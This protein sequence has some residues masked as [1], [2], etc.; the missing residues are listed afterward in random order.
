MDQTSRSRRPALAGA[1]LLGAALLAGPRLAHAAAPADAGAF[2]AYLTGRFAAE[3]GDFALALRDFEKVAPD[4]ADRRDHPAAGAAGRRDGDSPQAID[5]ARKLPDNPSPQLVLA[6]VDAKTATGTAPSAASCTAA[7]GADAGAAAAAGRL[8]AAGRRPHRRGAG[9]ARRG[10]APARARSV[11][12]LHAAMI[13]DL[14]GRRPRRTASTRSP[15]V[16]AAPNLRLARSSRAGRRA[17]AARASPRRLS[18]RSANAGAELALAVPGLERAVTVRPVEQRDRRHRRS[19]SRL[20]R[21]AAP[22]GGRGL[23]AAAAA[24]G[25]RPAAR[26]SRRRGC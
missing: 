6:D 4:R 9:D 26:I 5:L 17:R 2:G 25:A 3:H 11:Y 10:H 1:V 16:P 8:G 18:R 22:A 12:A 7:P 21:R 19:L 20:G 15:R 13:A 23:R 14:A 24:S